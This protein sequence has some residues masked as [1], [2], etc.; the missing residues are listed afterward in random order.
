MNFV[1][2][3]DNIKDFFNPPTG[4]SPNHSLIVYFWWLPPCLDNFTFFMS[5]VQDWQGA[6]VPQPGS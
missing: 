4:T 3:I 2:I 5:A 6:P 1:I